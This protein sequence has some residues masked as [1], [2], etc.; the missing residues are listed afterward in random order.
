MGGASYLMTTY[1]QLVY[2]TG[3]HPIYLEHFVIFLDGGKRKLEVIQMQ[4]MHVWRDLQI[5]WRT[6]YNTNKVT[7]RIQITFYKYVD[8]INQKN[9]HKWRMKSG[10]SER[11]YPLYVSEYNI[12]I[13]VGNQIKVCG[14]WDLL[15]IS[16]SIWCILSK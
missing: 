12:R 3:T 9:S 5:K 8:K 10:D 13:F 16:F 7:T 11:I 15:K 6:G 14:Y 1:S 2:L 4:S